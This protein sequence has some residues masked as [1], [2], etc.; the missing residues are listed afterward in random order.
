MRRTHV[1]GVV[2]SLVA[3]FL[4]V[5][6]AP[7]GAPCHEG[8]FVGAPY[9]VDEGDG[10]VVITYS[11]GAGAQPGGTVDYQTEDGTAKAPADYRS[12]SGTLRW[13]A[14][15]GTAGG[16][17][18]VSGVSPAYRGFEVPIQ[19]DT[20]DEPGETFKINMSHFTGC[21]DAAISEKTATVT[22]VDDDP[23]P[24]PKQS[25]QASAPP[26]QTPSKTPSASPTSAPLKSAPPP[27]SPGPT[28]TF[29]PVA[30]PDSNSGGGISGGALAG[31][32]A[33]VIVVGG[34][35][36]LLVRRRFLS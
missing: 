25:T 18:S 3:G 19:Q 30:G 10:K 14:A 16:T 21:F 2:V 33:G 15:G 8:S 4:L 26:K 13:G 7:A 32:V 24:K 17:A 11:N 23:A 31:I 20:R 35:V 29:V 5:L 34:G 6:A 27:G 1:L 9:R 36:A 22:I 28:Q 12:T